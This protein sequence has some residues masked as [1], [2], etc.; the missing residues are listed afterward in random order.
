MADDPPPPPDNQPESGHDPAIARYWMLHLMRIGGVLLTGL[1]AMMIV[2]RIE[3]P[4]VLGFGLFALGA[5]EFFFL[6]RMLAR[7]WKSP[8][9]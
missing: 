4:P 5:F 7:R 6:P 2:G 1:G 9:A 8:D 3:A